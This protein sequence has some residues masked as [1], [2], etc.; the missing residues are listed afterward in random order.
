MIPKNYKYV[1]LKPEVKEMLSEC[2][3]DFLKHHPELEEVFIT[4]NK[5]VYEMAKYY[6]Q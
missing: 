3:K 2:K 6:L 5:I 4:D 1:A